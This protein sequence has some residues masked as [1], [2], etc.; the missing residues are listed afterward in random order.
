[1]SDKKETEIQD[2]YTGDYL[3]A[4][5]DD[6]SVCLTIYGNGIT[7][8]FPKQHWEEIKSELDELIN[9]EHNHKPAV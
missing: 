3:N 4:W 9:G 7:L 6:D 8:F 1:M 2:L 5:E